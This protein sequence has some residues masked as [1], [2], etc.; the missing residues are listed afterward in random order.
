MTIGERFAA[1]LDARGIKQAAL[2]AQYRERALARGREFA[3]ETIESHISRLKKSEP[4]AVRF[5]FA[6][7][8]DARDLLELLSVSEKEQDAHFRDANALLSPE[9]RPVRL[10]VDLSDTAPG[11]SLVQWGSDLADK[12]VLAIEERVALV[13]TESQRGY[14]LPRCTPPGRVEVVVVPDAVQ[15]WA[16]TQ[17]LAS[18]GAVVVSGRR[19]DPVTRWIA[20]ELVPQRLR[21]EPEAGVRRCAAG[22]P[23][24]DAVADRDCFRLDRILGSIVPEQPPL[25]LTATPCAQRALLGKLL[26]GHPITSNESNY[27]GREQKP[28][29]ARTRAAWGAAL[30]VEAVAT[31][32]QWA[33]LLVER[34]KTLGVAKIVEGDERALQSQRAR[35]ARGGEAPRGVRVGAELHLINASDRLREGTKDLRGVLFHD[36]APRTFAFARIHNVVASTPWEAWLDDPYMDAALR[37]IDPEGIDRDELEFARA[38]LLLH[39]KLSPRGASRDRGW[40]SLLGDL[41]ANDPPPVAIRVPTSAAVDYNT[42][43]TL[44]PS[45]VH[46]LRATQRGCELLGVPALVPPRLD[47]SS[48]IVALSQTHVSLPKYQD[49]SGLERWCAERRFLLPKIETLGDLDA[50]FDLFD[51]APSRASVS[52]ERLVRERSDEANHLASLGWTASS[53]PIHAGFWRGADEAL[54][55]VWIVLRR[56]IAHAEAITLHDG[57]GLIEVASGLVAVISATRVRST[58]SAGLE[59]EF[60][61]WPRRVTL[62]TFQGSRQVWA[63]EAPDALPTTSILSEIG[64]LVAQTNTYRTRVLSQV[65]TQVFIASGDLRVCITFRATPWGPLGASLSSPAFGALGTGALHADDDDRAADD[66]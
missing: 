24:D 58:P 36:E 52:A 66:E 4:V 7:L 18:E 49:S 27:Y 9:E 2:A 8:T 59:A 20:L 23:I 15:G 33:G 48:A 47:R 21:M 45:S 38:A 10:V 1:L 28:V 41:L 61:F 17:E 57:S 22:Q 30:G 51:L 50:L 25:P 43:A 11:E 62:P 60:W 39:N 3:Q 40:R 56:A 14:L 64:A 53:I 32:E 12:V 34:A 19:H 35:V 44:L 42:V 13:V 29:D 54:A 63:D 46:K 5:F 37:R 31:E 26:L 16:R 65:P 6:D 55:A